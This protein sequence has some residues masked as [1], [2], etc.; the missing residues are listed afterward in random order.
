MSANIARP[1]ESE[2]STNVCAYIE[3]GN[4]Y[5]PI[6]SADTKLP[7]AIK[8]LHTHCEFCYRQIQFSTLAIDGGNKKANP[9]QEEALPARLRG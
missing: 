1:N 6:C 3:I 8:R 7:L 2:A 9:N 5:R 4:V